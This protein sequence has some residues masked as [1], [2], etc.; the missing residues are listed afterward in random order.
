MTKKTERTIST[1]WEG[2]WSEQQPIHDINIWRSSM[3]ST[4]SMK[5]P[6]SNFKFKI[7]V[8]VLHWISKVHY[9]NLFNFQYLNPNRI[10]VKNKDFQFF[11]LSIWK[12]KIETS[13][14]IDVQVQYWSSEL[15]TFYNE[16]QSSILNKPFRG[17]PTSICQTVR[18]PSGDKWPIPASTWS[19]RQLN[20]NS[21][22]NVLGAML[23]QLL[24]G[25]AFIGNY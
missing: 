17:P 25:N 7:E 12:S 24:I 23:T 5:L 9:W 18:Q 19:H 10:I 13:S 8:K 22:L 20:R 4:T 1:T 6:Y 16:V 3:R 14:I 21:I 2:R 11:N 15:K